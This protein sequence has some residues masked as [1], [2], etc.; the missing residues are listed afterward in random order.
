[1]REVGS[2]GDAVGP[3]GDG[4]SE[5]DEVASWGMTEVC[6]SGLSARPPQLF[7]MA[8]VVVSGSLSAPGVP[9]RWE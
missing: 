4:G 8:S 1:M 5:D 6:V 2:W 9:K 7:A 3:W